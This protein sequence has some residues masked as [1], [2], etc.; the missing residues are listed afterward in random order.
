M[1]SSKP[2][3][4]WKLTFLLKGTPHGFSGG[5]TRISYNTGNNVFLELAT[6]FPTHCLWEFRSPPPVRSFKQTSRGRCEWPQ[7]TTNLPRV[8]HWAKCRSIFVSPLESMD[9]TLSTTSSP[10]HLYS[11]LLGHS[12]SPLASFN[13]CW[14]LDGCDTCKAF[15]MIFMN[16]LYEAWG[17]GKITPQPDA[18]G[19]TSAHRNSSAHFQ[20]FKASQYIYSQNTVRVPTDGIH[21]YSGF[22]VLLSKLK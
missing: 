5:P 20:P 18:G 13:L 15:H 8:V 3:E 2:S 6:N 11:A 1:I 14:T 22:E 17:L 16:L 21:M 10:S 19:H 12:F 9:P 7:A 4:W